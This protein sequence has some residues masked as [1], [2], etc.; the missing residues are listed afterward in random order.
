MVGCS[1]LYKQHHCHFPHIFSRPGRSQGLLYKQP[2]IKLFRS[3]SQ[4][5]PPTTFWR[6]NTQTFR[7]SSFSYKIDYVKGI[8]D[9]SKSQRASKSHY[10]L[11]SHGHCTKG[12]DLARWWS[13]I[14]LGLRLQSAS[15]LAARRLPS[16]N[17]N[18]QPPLQTPPP[19][20]PSPNQT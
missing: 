13:C 2:G 12:V 3:V 17:P 15:L 6:L 16:P 20:P 10:W 19:D 9:L 11:K 7:D 1:L 5:F 4:P 8:K 14:G 18:H